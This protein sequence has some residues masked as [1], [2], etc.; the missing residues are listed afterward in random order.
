M[1][2]EDAPDFESLVL[3]ERS[4]FAERA[5][6]A[7][8]ALTAAKSRSAT[9]A[10]DRPKPERW[11]LVALAILG[12]LLLSVVIMISNQIDGWLLSELSCDDCGDDSDTRLAIG[13]TEDH[14][15]GAEDPADDEDAHIFGDD[16]LGP[17]PSQHRH[18]FAA[19]RTPWP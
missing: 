6:L 19:G 17:A 5:A 1:H 9:R 7:E 14:P 8:R 16:D 13:A 12:L 11:Q 10:T 2:R 3:A 15:G 4:E 18:V